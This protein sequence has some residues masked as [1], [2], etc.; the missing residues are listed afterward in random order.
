[1]ERAESGLPVPLVVAGSDDD[2]DSVR[3]DVV[4]AVGQPEDGQ[5][6]WLTIMFRAVCSFTF[7]GLYFV[8]I[9]FVSYIVSPVLF[10]RC[11]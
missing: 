5:F 6:H 11:V 4:P 8:F 9:A 2:D 10:T 1:M 7:L 3:V